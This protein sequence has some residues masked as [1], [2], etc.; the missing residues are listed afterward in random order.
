MTE[1]PY[2]ASQ[3]AI[4][5]VREYNG[6][7]I[8]MPGSVCSFLALNNGF[9]SDIINAGLV[10]MASQLNLNFGREEIL[11]DTLCPGQI[12]TASKKWAKMQLNSLLRPLP[13]IIKQVARLELPI[14]IALAALFLALNESSFVAGAVLI[15]YGWMTFQTLGNLLPKLEGYF[16]Q[17]YAG[18]RGLRLA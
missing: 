8:V 6:G 2:I 4:P 7:W 18:E 9:A 3:E 1:A 10:N 12:V 14:D 5:H 11:A 17:A 15:V 16:R 13:E